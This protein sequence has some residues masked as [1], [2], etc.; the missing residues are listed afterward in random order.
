MN[1][2]LAVL[3]SLLVA[4]GSSLTRGAEYFVDGR[5]GSDKNAGTIERSWKSLAKAAAT[6]R[7]G[8]TVLI[9]EGTYRLKESI[10]PQSNGSDQRPI[11]FSAFQNDEFA[12][13]RHGAK[14]RKHWRVPTR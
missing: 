13:R 6:L 7:A 3:F 8:D 14:R 10:R 12:M 1:P 9:R 5:S 4:F 2:L 11:T